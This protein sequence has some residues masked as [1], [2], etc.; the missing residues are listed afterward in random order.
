MPPETEGILA[1]MAAGEVLIGDGALGTLLLDRGLAPGA[2]PES[3]NLERPDLLEDIAREYAAVGAD[4]VGTNTFGASPLKLAHYKL[5]DR[6]EEINAKGVA[7][8]RKAAQPG[9][10]SDLLIWQI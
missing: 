4:I 9:L 8:A 10:L 6:C 3:L 7:A 2:C 1:R 5:Q